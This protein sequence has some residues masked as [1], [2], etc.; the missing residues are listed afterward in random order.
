MGEVQSELKAISSG[1][2]FNED[3]SIH[4]LSYLI[5]LSS[6]LPLRA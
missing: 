5:E 3:E 2:V 6:L 1:N 4:E